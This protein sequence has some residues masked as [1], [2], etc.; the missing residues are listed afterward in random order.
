MKTFKL[1]A[2]I[3]L[4][5][6]IFFG[7]WTGAASIGAVTGWNAGNDSATLECANGAV[8]ISFLENGAISFEIKSDKLNN[9]FPDFV[10]VE[11]L[12]AKTALKTDAA[13]GMISS[14]DMTVKIAADDF[15]F[16]VLKNGSVLMQL[17]PGGVDIAGDGTYTLTFNNIGKDKIF[18]LGEPPTDTVAN[19]PVD[20]DYRKTVRNIWNRHWS[21][22]DL[23]VPLLYDTGGY[24][25]FV[26]NPWKAQFDVG[27]SGPIR[28]SADGGPI[29]FFV[30]DAPDPRTMVKSYTALTGRPPMPPRWSL[31][32]MQSKY[33]YVNEADYR[34][35]IKN[36]RGKQIPC[37]VLIFDLDWFG[38]ETMGNFWWKKENFPDHEKLMDDMEKDG[39]KAIVITEPYVMTKSYNYKEALDKSYFSMHPDGTPYEFDF[40]GMRASLLDF[41]NEAA[42]K[43]YAEKVKRIRLSGVDAWWTDLNEPETTPEDHKYLLGPKE[44]VHN[45]QGFFMNKAI[46]DMYLEEFP[47]ERL[48]MMSR[49]GFAGSQRLG[50]G[51]WSGDVRSTWTDLRDQIP[52]GLNS[53]LSGFANWNS[54]TGGFKGG[55]PPPDL[56]TRWIQFSTF[57]PIMRAHGTHD[58]REPWSFGEE[59]ERICKNFIELRM[60]LIPYLYNLYH[61]A[62]IDG[63]P[64]IR[65]T[66]MEAPGEKTDISTQFFYGDSLLVAPVTDPMVTRSKKRVTLPPGNWTYFWDDR[67]LEGPRNISIPVT[68]YNIPVFVREGSIIPMAPVMQYSTEKPV[69]PLT[70]HYYPGPAAST[71][72]LYEDDGES[73]GYERGEFAITRIEAS[74]DSG[75]MFISIDKPSGSYK[76]MPEKRAYEIVVHH[77]PGNGKL[78]FEGIDSAEGTYD[79][80]AGTYTVKTSA[81]A[82]SLTVK[83]DF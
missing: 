14:G 79:G 32:Y 60:R 19:L 51:I 49:S 56:Y 5:S 34:W 38:K 58:P 7:T 80:S 61:E 69:D 28:Y 78:D 33:G 52:I 66:F 1:S 36:F 55:T 70:I 44:S 54:D 62:H 27:T 71:Y 83:I 48:L 24:A 73:R 57:N 31:G 42:Q 9:P 76:G 21:P 35:L 30:I 18:A 23:G 46:H 82:G 4:A 77:A 72:M 43:W 37:D 53:G 13:A 81:C 20:M 8:D 3:L 50:T 39:F 75:D 22:S 10:L 64:I 74:S 47:D 15:G 59:A 25:I 67:R 45:L 11:K 6:T 65:P 63:T 26:S 68:L 40:W 16:E 12:P 2:F 17:V 41:S 29:K